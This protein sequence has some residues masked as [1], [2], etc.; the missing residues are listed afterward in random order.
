MQRPGHKDVSVKMKAHT[1]FLLNV[2]TLTLCF[3]IPLKMVQ[4]SDGRR[5]LTY[6]GLLINSLIYLFASSKLGRNMKIR[7]CLRGLFQRFRSIKDSRFRSVT[8]EEDFSHYVVGTRPRTFTVEEPLVDDI[9]ETR[10]RTF[11]VE[12]TLVDDVVE[13]RPICVTVKEPLADD[14]MESRP[15]CFTIEETFSDD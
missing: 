11:T 14:I 3:Q 9:V 5:W 7:V 6:S 4:G 1:I 2:L 13:S 8:T 15:R 12:E 10:P